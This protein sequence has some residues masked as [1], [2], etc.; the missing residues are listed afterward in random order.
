VGTRRYDMKA[1]NLA[2]DTTKASAVKAAYD[3]LLDPK[4]RDLGLEAVA[5]RVGVTR[6]TLYNQFGS[7]S[8]LLLALFAELGRR[9]GADRVHVAMRLPDPV[10][11]VTKTIQASTRGLKREQH[12][13][14]KLFAFAALDAEV[15]KEVI[16]AERA[17]RS[18]L[19]HLAKRLSAARPLRI[20]VREAAALLASLTSFQ[21]F[22]AFAVDE[23]PRLVERRLLHVACSSLGIEE[24]E[25]EA[26]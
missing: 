23:G 3:M 26:K 7:R 14:R 24:H 16:R 19:L 12:A 2:L 10:E 1:R 25:R 17:R 8:G 6:V 21:A 4:C 18:S 22:E 13:V 20:G 15:Q 11:A 9:I 5:A